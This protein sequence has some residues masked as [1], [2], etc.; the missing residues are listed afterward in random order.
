MA[1]RRR[2]RRWYRS[3]RWCN[4]KG[5]PNKSEQAVVDLQIDGLECLVGRRDRYVLLRHPTG[6]KTRRYKRWVQPDLNRPW[7][8]HPDFAYGWRGP[9]K[10]GQPLLVVEVFGF[11]KYHSVQEAHYLKAEYERAGV[12][13]LVFSHT[14]CRRNPEAV[15]RRIR[16]AI[17]WVERRSS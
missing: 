3:A 10:G 1:R 15:G 13:C 11:G 16:N 14:I 2:R 9:D 8:K 17:R 12:V 6:P 7:R 4:R 5:I